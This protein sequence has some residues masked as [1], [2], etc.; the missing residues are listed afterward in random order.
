METMPCF[1]SLLT[2]KCLEEKDYLKTMSQET[3]SLVESSTVNVFSILAA[4]SVLSS[5]WPC[6]VHKALAQKNQWHQHAVSLFCLNNCIH[7]YIAFVCA[8]SYFSFICLQ[9]L[10]M[11]FFFLDTFTPTSFAFLYSCPFQVVTT[12]VSLWV[13]Q[14]VILEYSI[15]Q[16]SLL[17]GSG[18]PFPSSLMFPRACQC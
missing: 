12:A 1:F 2:L 9:T 7:V 17:S 4:P 18:H 6:M 14:T 11:T 16:H 13:Q 10:L 15:P 8:F 5:E 3:N